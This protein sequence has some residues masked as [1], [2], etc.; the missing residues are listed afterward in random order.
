M[1]RRYLTIAVCAALWTAPLLAVAGQTMY[2]CGNKYQDSPCESGEGSRIGKTS[3]APQAQAQPQGR[4]QAQFQ[5]EADAAECSSR[6]K[7]SL[8]I[9]WAREA[10]ATAEK[11]I[12]E[13]DKKGLSSRQAAQEKR[14]IAAVYEKRGS[15]MSIRS[16]IEGEC[17]AEKEKVRQAQTLA[18]AAAKLMQDVPSDAAPSRPESV[19]SEQHTV[20]RSQSDNGSSR[21]QEE[22]KLTCSRLTSQLT[23]VKSEQHGGASANRMNKLNDS[24]R[25]LEK[26]LRSEGC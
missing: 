6:G 25:E 1:N 13:V 2:R 21:T 4:S 26:A 17:I 14:L 20:A 12:A 22:H 10:G 16:D 18:A 3:S 15:S 9:S 7:D 5:T 23:S 11:Q 24:K 8:K 19:T